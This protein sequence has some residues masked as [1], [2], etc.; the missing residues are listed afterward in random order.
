MEAMNTTPA[1]QYL[2]MSTEH[3]QYS[4]GNQS[5]A[6]GEFAKKNG[7][8]IVRTYSDAG[9]SGLLL[10]ERIALQELLRDVM[11]GTADY[12]AIL[13]YDVS[14]WG[15]FQDADE[16]AHY[17]FLCRQNGVAVHYCAEPFTGSRSFPNAL[18]KALKRVMASEYSRELSAK[19]REGSKRVSES[20]FRTGGEPGYGLRRMLVSGSRE[21]RFELKSGE[22]KSLQSDRVVLVPGPESE[23][24]CVKDI[25]RMFVEEGKWPKA[26]AAELREKGIPYFGHKKKD[27]YPEAVSRILKN[28]KYC[29]CSVFGQSSFILRT[30]RTHYPQDRWTVTRGA[31]EG[32][33]DQQTFDRV[34]AIFKSQTFHKADSELLAVLRGLLN[35]RGRLSERLVNES[36]D[37][38]SVRPFTRR[39]G[40]L[41]EAF[42][43]VGYIGPRLSATHTRRRLRNLRSQIVKDLVSTYP[44]HIKLLKPN[45]H[46]RPRFEVSGAM[47]SLH[48]CMCL[49]RNSGRL[50]WLLKTV[51]AEQN[52]IGLIARLNPGNESIMDMFI[53]PNTQ[54]QLY[55][56]LALDDPWLDRGRHL[57][58]IQDLIATVNYFC[59]SS[60]S[61]SLTPS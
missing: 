1:A 38:P 18:M 50:Y 10:K 12:K 8:T 55:F 33:V 5:A 41:S 58:T 35:E 46:F 49:Q 22:R 4:L 42:E 53:V 45:G 14:R 28:P 34:Q 6:I 37:L 13:V 57:V 23:V 3:Q 24:A 59:Q 25:Y 9:K 21:P 47:M 11:T 61:S 51:P 48:L 40:S 39:F 19:V 32:L 31:W 2:R 17:E 36:R 26:I 44:E 56:Q 54:G 43:R 60:H 20:G 7:F 30:S 52:C 27:W 16:A 29:G 15:R